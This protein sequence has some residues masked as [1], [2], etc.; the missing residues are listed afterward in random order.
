[1]VNSLSGGFMKRS[2]VGVA[3]LFFFAIIVGFAILVFLFSE[4]SD[5][6]EQGSGLA[7]LFGADNKIG[8]IK[9]E[10][11]ISSSDT[12]LK[13]LKKFGKRSSIKS[14]LLRINSPGGAVAPAQEIYRQIGV[15]RKKKPVVASIET[16]GASAAYYIA[17]NA[18]RVVCSRGTITGSIG[19]IMILAEIHKVID[20]I[21]VNV[22]VI[23]AGKYKDIG[24]AVRPLT[25]E[26]RKILESFA[27]EVHEQFIQDVA[28]ARK[29]KIEMDK[30]RTV[31]DGSFF[32]GE[33][34]HKLGLVDTLGN[35]YDAVKIAGKLGG[36]KGEPELVYPKKKWGGYLDLVLGSV[37]GVVSGATDASR[38]IQNPPLVR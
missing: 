4:F 23:K 28:T 25:E 20:K 26:E 10:G 2:R 8:V 15:V 3:L 35:F 34:A 17:S 13:Q 29:G 36:I 24:S 12:I 9:I 1:M 16:V 14:I 32:S 6:D 7:D 38:L 30:L 31:A 5:S 22:N 27:N 21:G 18:D 19:V 11:T 37:A 33:K